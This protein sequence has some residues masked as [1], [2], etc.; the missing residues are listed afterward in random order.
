MAW[1]FLRANSLMP[2]PILRFELDRYL[3]WPGQAPSYKIGERV[4]LQVRE[5][6]RRRE[7]TAAD[8]RDFH[9]R[10]LNLGGLGL[11]TFRAA[12]TWGVWASTLSGRRWTPA[13]SDPSLN[14]RP[15]LVIAQLVLASA[16]PARRD[17]LRRA[18]IDPLVVVSTVDEEAVTAAAQWWPRPYTPI[19]L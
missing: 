4:W 2:E 13:P 19:S 6:M 7:G 9:R 18:G 14:D 16:S 11:D 5:Q 8:L 3:G 17:I 10:A 1:S 15:A 12:M